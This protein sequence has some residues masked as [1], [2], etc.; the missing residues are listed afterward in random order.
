MTPT[1]FQERLEE[2]EGRVDPREF[3]EALEYVRGDRRRRRQ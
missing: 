3:V 2:T 1:Y